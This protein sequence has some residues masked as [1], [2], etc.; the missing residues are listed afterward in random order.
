MIRQVLVRLIAFLFILGFPFICEA[1]PSISS[2]TGTIAD[3]NSITISG[4]TF[5]TGPTIHKYDFFEQSGGAYDVGDPIANSWSAT[6]DGA[7]QNIPV[8]YTTNYRTGSTKHIRSEF[9]TS[10]W[11][12]IF[13]YDHGATLSPIYTTFWIK[14]TGGSNC[15][16]VKYHQI[17]NEPRSS[18]YPDTNILYVPSGNDLMNM[19]SESETYVMPSEWFAGLNDTPTW[20][21]VEHYVVESDFENSPYPADGIAKVWIQRGG[22]G[23]IFTSV[24]DETTKTNDNGAANH[25]EVAV[26]CEYAKGLTGTVTVDWDDIYISN[27]LARVEIGNNATWANCTHREIQIVT[28]WSATSSTFTLHQGSISSANLTNGNSYL[29]IIDSSGVPNTTGYQLGRSCAVSGTATVNI[30]ESAVPDGGKEIV[31]DLTG[32]TWDAN[33]GTDCAETTALIQGLDAATT[34]TNGWNNRVRDVLTFNEV[35]KNTTTRV[36]ITLHAT[37]HAA[38]DITAQDGSEIITVT[39]DSSCL[40]GSTNITGSPTFGIGYEA[41]GSETFDWV[42]NSDGPGIVANANG[43]SVVAP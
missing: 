17:R 35:V 39:V 37:N 29:F 41:A 38:Y 12:S 19:L 22:E 24:V 20:E 26:F 40:A 8:Y 28:A 34:P 4:S 33:I 25:W 6:A 10:N 5:G 21:R 31:L 3:G 18:V 43:P 7:P 13:W 23:N 32:D 11:N 36:T 16:H 9:D 27:S 42:T 15:D 30:T 14:V 1:A 2:Y